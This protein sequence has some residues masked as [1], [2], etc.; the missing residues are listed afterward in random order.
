MHQRVKSESGR[1]TLEHQGLA[2]Y[3]ALLSDI[4]EEKHFITYS[5]NSK[6]SKES[7]ISGVDTE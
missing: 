5:S 7:L 6:A 4:G 1:K 2:I 3:T